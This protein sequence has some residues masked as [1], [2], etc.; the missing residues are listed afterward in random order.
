MR[1][2]FISNEF[3]FD[4]RLRTVPHL[5]RALPVQYLWKFIA[6]LKA[7]L[8]RAFQHDAFATAKASAY[9]CI[10]SF[11]PALLVLGAVLASSH[12]FEIYTREVSHVLGRI[13]PAGNTTAIEYVRGKGDR[14]MKFLVGT[15]LL[16]VWT[17][18]GVVISWIEGFRAAY[19]LPKI[20]GLVKERAIACSLVVLAGIPMSIA[21]ILVV[22]GSQIEGRAMLHTGHRLGPFILLMWTGIRWLLAILTSV[23]VIALIYHNAVPRTQRWHTVLPGAS[24]ATGMWFGATLFFGWYLKHFGDYNLIYGSL[25]VGIA[26]L[27]WMYL[28]SLMV[29][30]GAEFNALLFPRAVLRRP[31]PVEAPQWRRAA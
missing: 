30:V 5:A 29:L 28:V 12:R 16:T 3:L 24:L 14:S 22:F 26:L 31:E 17:A 20:W 4:G 6:L 27:I 13:L 23:A 2:R 7:A 1:V 9:S 10:L 8:W 15:S 19:Q 18:S 25:G 21:T 11:F